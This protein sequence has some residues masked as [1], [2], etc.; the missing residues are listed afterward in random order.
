MKS[1]LL[2]L[3]PVMALLLSG[4]AT[5]YAQTN[6]EPP[7]EEPIAGRAPD[8]LGRLNLSPDQLQQIRKIQRDMRDERAAANQ[9]LRESNR[10]LEDAL[11]TESPEEQVIEQRI[12]AVNAAQN[13]QLR[14][15]IQTEM[16]IRRVLNPSQL[17]ILKDIRIRAADLIRAQQERREMRSGGNG[18]RPQRN[19][20]APLR[21][22]GALPPPKPY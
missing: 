3:F 17:A 18:L 6:Q 22:G 4:G 14:A 2:T 13:A 11:D 10:A 8:L 19:G 15:R 9:R 7:I 12:Q 16:R 21:R 1:F 20:I 5:V